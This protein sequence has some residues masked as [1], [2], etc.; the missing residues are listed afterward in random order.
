MPRLASAAVSASARRA[1]YACVASTAV[2]A[3]APWLDLRALAI[4]ERATP[5]P[6]LGEDH[7][8]G[9]RNLVVELGPVRRELVALDHVA[10]LALRRSQ[11]A[12]AVIVD[13]ARLDDE[14]VA[15]KPPDRRAERRRR[16]RGCGRRERNGARQVIRLAANR[17][18]LALIDDLDGVG[19]HHRVRHARH[20]AVSHGLLAGLVARLRAAALVG[21]LRRAARPWESRDQRRPDAEERARAA[22][23]QLEVARD[24]EARGVADGLRPEVRLR[25]RR[26]E[27]LGAV[28]KQD[29]RDPE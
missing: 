17:E 6:R 20:L 12:V 28:R 10:L 27:Q 5:D 29:V 8:I 2:G 24:E 19:A 25:A 22:V 16:A 1:S 23:R 3:A 26:R 7:G 13:A 14:L 18:P 9:D 11:V 21:E 4:N 15:R